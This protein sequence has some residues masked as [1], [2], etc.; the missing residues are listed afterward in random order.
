MEVISWY[1]YYLYKFESPY[2]AYLIFK[3]LKEGEKVIVEDVIED[4]VGSIWNGEYLE[5]MYEEPEEP[6]M[7]G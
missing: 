6:T 4:I 7:I 3:D 2:A 5:L 1:S